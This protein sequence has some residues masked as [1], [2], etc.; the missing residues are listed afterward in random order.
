MTALNTA[1]KLPTG[2]ILLPEGRMMY[3]ALFRA[4]LPRGETDPKK[5]SWQIT[6]LFPKDT[7]LTAL[8]KA[9]DD[10]IAENL[11]EKQR[12][13][14]KV[15]RPILLTADQARLAE[16]AEDFPRMVRLGAKEYK[17]DGGKRQAPQVLDPA[18]QEV[19]EDDEADMVYAGRWARAT[20]N[21]F[22][23][24]HDTGGKGVSLGL[25]N[26][27]LLRHDEPLEAGRVKGTAEFEAVDDGALEDLMG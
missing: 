18:M 11:T 8:E 24:D 9:I 16:L 7:D 10:V 2:N 26:V 6:L 21:P 4:T 20:C 25:A 12:A 13:T 27:Q 1:R 19:H 22:F 15:K 3:P 14:A 17:R 5:G 23:Y